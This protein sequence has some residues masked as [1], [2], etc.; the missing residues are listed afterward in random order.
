M[1]VGSTAGLTPPIA[2][3]TFSCHPSLPLC[4]RHES[5]DSSWISV[6]KKVRFAEMRRQERTG[7][8]GAMR[9]QTPHRSPR[10]AFWGGNE[11][12]AE[13]GS[14]WIEWIEG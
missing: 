3:Q 8:M 7:L 4:D 9:P 1:R 13:S 6:W 5:S 2:S 12:C 14:E 10:Q 11:G